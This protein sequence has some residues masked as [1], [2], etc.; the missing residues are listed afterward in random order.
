MAVTVPF[1]VRPASAHGVGTPP[2]S[3]AVTIIYHGTYRANYAGTK[4]PAS[5]TGI[6]GETDKVNVT[7][8]L[9]WTGTMGELFP[10]GAI[11]SPSLRFS[12][13]T[14]TGRFRMTDT[15]ESSGKWHTAECHA[16]V[17]PSQESP[18]F[19]VS[20][21]AGNTTDWNFSV[22]DF[23][24]TNPPLS[25][26]KDPCKIHSVVSGPIFGSHV[27]LSASH[28]GESKSEYKVPGVIVNTSLSVV[29]GSTYAA[30]GDSFSSGNF[31]PFTEPGDPCDRSYGAYPELYDKDKVDFLACSGATSANVLE[32][33]VPKVPKGT[34]LVSVTAGGD[35][36]NLFGVFKVCLVT[37]L[38]NR[39]GPLLTGK[40][41]VACPHTEAK[42][43]GDR[44]KAPATR[45]K[46]A[47]ISLFKAIKEQAKRVYVLGYPNPLPPRFKSGTCKGLE[48]ITF[49][50]KSKNTVH[51]PLGIVAAD[52]PFLYQLVE[53]MNRV[54][55]E[56]ANAAGVNYVEPSP[57]FARHT[58][59]AKSPWF[60]PLKIGPG[61]LSRIGHPNAQGQQEMMKELRASAGA[62]PQ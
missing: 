57:E 10:N 3:Q 9:S 62:P 18:T 13:A 19:N 39:L 55:Q 1:V 17:V 25:A 45:E 6:V 16:S 8:T 36:V 4:D 38:I 54:V 58:V 5:P 48:D 33:Q 31:E 30:L 26:L 49:I 46:D 47:L 56:A 44:L 21:I 50:G 51:L 22:T 24:T 12:Q 7:W 61:L 2:G 40:K 59:C 43:V 11:T 60:F 32:N 34:K 14:V 41:P 42:S 23:V 29:L 37:D 52:V 15:E 20:Q 28:G 35:D 27:S 53:A